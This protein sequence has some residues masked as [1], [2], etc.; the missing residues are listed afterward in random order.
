MIPI[1]LSNVSPQVVIVPQDSLL[2][3]LY[4]HWW[5]R[6]LLYT[7]SHHNA[8]FVIAGGTAG[9]YKVRVIINANFVAAGGSG[10]CYILRV[11]IM[12]TLLSL[13]ALEVVTLSQVSRVCVYVCVWADWTIRLD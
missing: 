13:V 8:N 3:Q 5:P 4:C 6:S 9:C 11:I 10:G 2:Y 1:L 12:P 7:E